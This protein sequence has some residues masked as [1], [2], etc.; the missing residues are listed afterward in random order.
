[1]DLHVA[2]PPPGHVDGD[3]P[4][5]LGESRDV[6]PEVAPAGRSRPRA[7]QE[8]NGMPSAG[9]VDVDAEPPLLDEAAGARLADRCAH[10][11]LPSRARFSATSSIM[12]SCPP[13]VRLRPS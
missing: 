2:P 9:L 5:V 7:V 8:D 11:Q 1:G 12:S 6:R 3:R 10:L 4:K 13:T